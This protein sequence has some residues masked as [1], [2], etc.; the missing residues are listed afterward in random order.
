MASWGWGWV[1]GLRPRAGRVGV[2][3]S[4]AGGRVWAKSGGGE[5][6]ARS[7]NREE[8]TVAGARRLRE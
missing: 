2:K 7:R 6:V 3:F 1:L 8:T 4:Q 5:G